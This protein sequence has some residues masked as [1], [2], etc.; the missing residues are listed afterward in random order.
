[1][2]LTAGTNAQ[3]VSFWQL[4]FTNF[5]IDRKTP[6]RPKVRQSKKKRRK[7]ARAASGSDRMG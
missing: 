2:S 6:P 5:E 3:A 1:M 7:S 4:A